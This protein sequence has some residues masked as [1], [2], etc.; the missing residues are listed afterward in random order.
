[1]KLFA[2]ATGEG[3]HLTD[4]VKLPVL[5]NWTQSRDLPLLRGGEFRDWWKKHEKEGR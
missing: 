3:A 1:M 5:K 2:K 4:K